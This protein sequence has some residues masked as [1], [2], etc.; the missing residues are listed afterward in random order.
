MDLFL[1]T[2]NLQRL[3]CLKSYWNDSDTE[4]SQFVEEESMIAQGR[5]DSGFICVYIRVW[6][7]VVVKFEKGY[8][9]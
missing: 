7:W 8:E 1:E 4:S 3:E 6:F 9:F 5:E 2:Q